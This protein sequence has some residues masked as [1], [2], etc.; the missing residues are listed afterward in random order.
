LLSAFAL[1]A[2]AQERPSVAPEGLEVED[3]STLQYG[4][5]VL[6]FI[7]DLDEGRVVAL[8]EA[9]MREAGIRPLRLRDTDVTERPFVGIWVQS[10]YRPALVG[11]TYN[12][13]FHRP[14][15]Y[16]TG[17]GPVREAFAVTWV[18][19]FPTAVG[20]PEERHALE[21][22]GISFARFLRDFS[23]ANNARRQ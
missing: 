18:D 17:W 6:G 20:F 19:G 13:S 2:V 1:E 22:I 5:I 14:V 8:V 3:A 16:Q 15:S 9:M 4:V 23:R 10:V 21:S 11:W 12:I 7:E